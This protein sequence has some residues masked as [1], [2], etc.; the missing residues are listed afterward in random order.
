MAKVAAGARLAF[1]E[2]L[3]TAQLPNDI[4]DRDIDDAI[5][6]MRKTLSKSKPTT[7][8]AEVDT[9]REALKPS[10]QLVLR[11]CPDAEQLDSDQWGG[12]LWDLYTAACSHT[13][14]GHRCEN[15]N[16]NEE[17]WSDLVTLLLT[18]PEQP[19]MVIRCFWTS[20][21][22]M[23]VWLSMLGGLV[24]LLLQLEGWSAK[25]KFY[26]MVISSLCFVAATTWGFLHF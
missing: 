3:S 16:G 26:I 6:K 8:G 19:P 18:S 14:A 2:A 22:M 23:V 25:S 15:L 12:L 9:M 13:V 11:S 21:R 24:T 20:R 7:L 4:G 10:L 17:A 1:R 5:R